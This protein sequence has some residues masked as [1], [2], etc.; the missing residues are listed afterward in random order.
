M[1][2]P[3]VAMTTKA[4]STASSTVGRMEKVRETLMALREEST[5]RLLLAKQAFD[6]EMVW[7]K[8]MRENPTEPLAENVVQQVL[9]GFAV[10]YTTGKCTA[11]Q[12]GI[13]LFGPDCL[14]IEEARADALM[15][16]G[17]SETFFTNDT[18][19]LNGHAYVLKLFP[20][21]RLVTRA[22]LAPTSKELK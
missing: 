1:M 13:N 19:V 8:R 18:V 22:I 2:T 4:Q 20:P 12:L 21:K 6:D 5:V 9:A 16:T 17:K 10:D 11:L 7:Q 14:R 15:S 3:P